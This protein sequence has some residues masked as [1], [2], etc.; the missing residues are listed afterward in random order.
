MQQFDTLVIGAGAAGLMCAA[1]LGQ[2]GHRVG[3]L[4]HS[5]K[6]AEKIRISGGGRCNFTNRFVSETH[7]VGENPA[8]ARHALK[9]FGPHDF[10]K[11][12]QSHRIPFHEKHKGQLFCDRASE[13]IINMLAAECTA[14]QV[15][16]L[17]PHEVQHIEVT[18][19]GF[20]LQSTA[21]PLKS[22][23]LV[24]ATGGLPV[25]KIGA[26]DFGLRWAKQWGHRLVDTR[27][28]LV[29]LTFEPAQ[30]QPWQHLAGVALPVQCKGSEAHAPW[31]D[32]DLLFTHR[33]LSGPGILQISSF[34]S[35]GQAIVINGSGAKSVADF[36]ATLVQTAQQTKAQLDTVLAQLMPHAPKRWLAASLDQPEFAPLRQRKMAELG[37]KQLGPL[38]AAFAD[39]RVVP[40]GTEGYRKAEVMRGGVAT[41]DI[42][43]K[44]MESQ[45]I[46]GLYWIG[47]VVDI[48]GW[49]GGYN[50]QWAW[51]S[52][53]C[54]AHAILQR[55]S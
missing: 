40:S 21:G 33:G 23:H 2:G 54:A 20:S 41:T 1:R 19:Q 32:E 9:A 13:D 53:V 5:S 25:P 42:N 31:F 29:P 12:V 6:L 46:S 8:F 28:A 47:E 26:T 50:F 24:M 3:L 44:T 10:I 11:L 55:K 7:F 38:A 37:K 52:A 4:D 17:R 27:P 48:T 34:W 16:M 39:W 30:W 22:R 14:G 18:D 36:Q 35:P 45:K 43:P 49:L 51:S 15:N